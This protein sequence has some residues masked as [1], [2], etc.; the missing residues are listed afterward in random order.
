MPRCYKNGSAACCFACLNICGL[1]SYHP[2]FR[3]IEIQLFLR[4]LEQACFWLPAFAFFAQAVG[5]EVYL[6]NLDSCCGE[7]LEHF[8]IHFIEIFP[9]AIAHTDAGLVCDNGYFVT[10]ILH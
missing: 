8:Q 2:A 9:G 4:S 5:A 10:C 7:M 3:K 1:I 6:I